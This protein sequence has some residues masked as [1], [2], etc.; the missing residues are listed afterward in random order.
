MDSTAYAINKKA[1]LTIKGT[2]LVKG[3][4]NSFEILLNEDK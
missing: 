1:Q 2:L 3:P 4:N